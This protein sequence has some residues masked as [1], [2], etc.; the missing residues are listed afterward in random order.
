MK[1]E[2]DVAAGSL[3][4]VW[5]LTA[6]DVANAAAPGITALIDEAKRAALHA[7]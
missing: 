2:N 3:D 4:K 7:S 6:Y 1:Q 5:G